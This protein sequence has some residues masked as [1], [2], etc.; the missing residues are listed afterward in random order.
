MGEVIQM[1]PSTP[2]ETELQKL[3]AA[4]EEGGL[5]MFLMEA[6]SKATPDFLS[7]EFSDP[8]ISQAGMVAA[9]VLRDRFASGD[10]A[11]VEAVRAYCYSIG[12]AYR[13][14]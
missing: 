5:V 2:A 8:V 11:F 4:A 3:V 6:G 1:M 12:A 13:A 9:H 7:F 10:V 14:I